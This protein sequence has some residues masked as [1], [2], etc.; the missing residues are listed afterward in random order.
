MAAGSQNT[1]LIEESKGSL[2]ICIYLR[3]KNKST[4]Q[5][6]CTFIGIGNHHFE[7][8]Y[9]PHT[10]YFFML[11]QTFSPGYAPKIIM[12]KEID[13]KKITL[14]FKW[15][16][17]HHLYEYGLNKIVEEHTGFLPCIVYRVLLCSSEETCFFYGSFTNDYLQRKT[18]FGGMH[19]IF[20]KHTDPVG[21]AA[22]FP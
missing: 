14:F 7:L 5:I 16:L 15:F 8:T 18:S 19:A 6:K 13:L 11:S 20:T 4:I 9:G 17:K 1:P 10:G 12:E 21:V 2:P 22:Q 3:S